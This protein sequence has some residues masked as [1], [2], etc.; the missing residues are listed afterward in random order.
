MKEGTRMSRETLIAAAGMVSTHS[1]IIGKASTCT[2]RDKS[3][4]RKKG[5]SHYGCVSPRVNGGDGGSSN[6]SKNF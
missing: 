6:G 4:E 5:V 1:T 2:P 3:Q